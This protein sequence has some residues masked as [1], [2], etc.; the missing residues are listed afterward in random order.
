[1]IRIGFCVCMLM[2][3]KVIGVIC[4]YGGIDGCVVDLM[5]DKF[6]DCFVWKECVVGIVMIYYFKI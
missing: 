2:M 6:V 3:F 1:M 5:I 4:M